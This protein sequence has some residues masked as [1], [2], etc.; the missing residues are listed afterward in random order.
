MSN[1]ITNNDHFLRRK[2]N[3]RNELLNKTDRYI[4]EDYP[5]S[6]EQKQIIKEYR[7][8]LREFINNNKDAL[9]KRGIYIELIIAKLY[10]F[11]HSRKS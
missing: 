8:Q 6:A 9:K 2:R 3:I 7:Q 10:Y 1:F 4:L 5:L 11:E